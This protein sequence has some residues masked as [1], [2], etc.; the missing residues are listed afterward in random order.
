MAV[1]VGAIVGAMVAVWPAIAAQ[2]VQLVK[3]EQ[4]QTVQFLVQSE[5]DRQ[6]GV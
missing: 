3:L 1:P 6:A 4:L 5:S 2:V